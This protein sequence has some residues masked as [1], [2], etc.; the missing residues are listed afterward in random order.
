[1]RTRT[2]R[3]HKSCRARVERQKATPANESGSIDFVSDRLFD[4]RRFRLLTLVDNFTKESLAIRLGQQHTGD[5][6]VAVLEQL[7][8]A[9]DSRRQWP[10]IQLEV[11]RLVGL[12]Q[13]GDARLQSTWHAH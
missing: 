5:D 3:R 8:A 13:R 12:L 4:G 1:M 11:A 6:V 10:G 2:P 7:Q 9:V